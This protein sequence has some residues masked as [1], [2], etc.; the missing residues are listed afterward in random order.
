MSAGQ[1]GRSVNRYEARFVENRWVC[2]NT[3]T[4]R[5]VGTFSDEES[6]VRHVAEMNSYCAEVRDE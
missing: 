5:W 6:A 1:E 3:V 2:W 4:D